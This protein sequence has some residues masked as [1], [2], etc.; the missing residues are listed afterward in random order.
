MAAFPDIDKIRFEGPKSKNMLAFHHYDENEVVEGKPMKDH[1]RF[2]VAYWHTFRGTGARSVRARHD[3]APLGSRR[4]HGRERQ[5]P[6]A[7]GLRVHGKAGRRISIAFTI[8]TSRPRASTLAETQQESRRGG[9][10]AQGRAA[11][12]RH[13]AVVGHGQPV[14]QSALHA[15]R[16]H[17]PQRRRV[18]LRRRAGQKGPRSDQGAGRRRATRSGAAAKA[19]RTCGTRT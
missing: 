1:F 19:I 14:Q 13:Q 11:A 5:E 17:Q 9:Q 2:A 3:A 4:R 16:R 18:R 12:H 15:R 8:A 10:G 7:R 6:R